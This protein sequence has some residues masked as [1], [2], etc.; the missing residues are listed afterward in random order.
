MNHKHRAQ[1]LRS[2]AFNLFLV[3]VFILCIVWLIYNPEPAQAAYYMT[4][5][6]Y[7]LCV[8]R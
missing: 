5:G 4:T 6:N 3:A 7:S 2:R 8:V 1:R